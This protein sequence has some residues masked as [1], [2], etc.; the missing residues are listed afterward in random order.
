MARAK[1][2]GVEYVSPGIGTVGNVLAEVV[3]LKANIKLVHVPYKSG[4]AAIV[5]LLA[6]RVKLGSLNWS[7]ARQHVGDG[8]LV[9]LTV[10]SAHRIA[11]APD[12]P[13]LTDLGY[14]DLVTTTWWALSG[15]PGLP[16]EI[17]EKLN[18]AA[19]KAIDSPAMR[20]QIEL[21]AIETKA[22]SPEEVTQFFQGEIDKW[23]PL[24]HTVI[25][26]E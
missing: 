11:A 23:V 8:T 22:M 3:A 2:D 19:N 5:D 24:V 18:G 6:G 1:P 12:L 26:S 4:N 15:P 17:V 9:P 25:K 16:R 20:K 21:N 10:S 13:T 7:T 14:P